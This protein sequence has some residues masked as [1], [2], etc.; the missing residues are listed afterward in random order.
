MCW[1]GS[2]KL[3]TASLL[4]PDEDGPVEVSRAGGE[5]DIVLVCEH[6]ASRLP[7]ALGGLGLSETVR[8]SHVAWD[9]G[10]L[11]VARMLSETLD[12]ALVAQA[13]SRLAY[14]CN[15]PPESPDAIP[16]RSEVFD[17]PGNRGLDDAARRQR[18]EALYHPFHAA[19]ESLLDARQTQGRKPVLVTV[20]SFTPVYFGIARDGELG[21]LHD[22]DPRFAEAMLDAASAAGLEDVRRNYPYSAAD[23]VTH[24]LR[25]H[26]V[27]RDIPNVMLEI[28][29]DLVATGPGQA[30]W[31]RRI[32]GL[33]RTA[34]QGM[35][36]QQKGD[37]RHDRR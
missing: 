20:H 14:D 17:V 2:R 18:A 33:L 28:R 6:A 34:S 24:T 1:T 5:S 4:G 21:I 23:G 27:P 3:T 30:E 13:Y 22:A 29:N 25:R 16:E 31:A 26:G 32:A 8:Q 15:R 11:A 10:A 36:V 19:I 7:A 35:I 9:I 12:A 37:H